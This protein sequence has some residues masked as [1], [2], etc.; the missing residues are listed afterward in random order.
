MNPVIVY[1]ATNTV[2]GKRYIGI[3]TRCLRIRITE[4]FKP[5]RGTR[6]RFGAAI[7][8]H[9]PSS[10]EF[11]V[12]E[13]WETFDEAKTAERRLIAGLNPEYNMTAGGDGTLGYRHTLNQRKHWSTARKGKS[14]KRRPMSEDARQHLS[15]IRRGKPPHKIA[16]WKHTPGS[17]AK[18]IASRDQALESRRRPVI[19]VDDRVSFRSATEAG[20]YYGIHP[21]SIGQV[22][23]GLPYRKTAGGR[24]FSF[25]EGA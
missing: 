16:G 3:T 17:I 4:H 21:T 7:K 9:G 5:S 12:L 2:N 25:I 20:R 22:C 1:Q 19:C 18:I 14:V 23:L 13:T 6:S 24:R 11:S 15:E 8:A 10:F